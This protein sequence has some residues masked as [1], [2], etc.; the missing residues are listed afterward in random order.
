MRVVW[1]V[2][3]AVE[4]VRALTGVRAF[5]NCRTAAVVHG[6][7]MVAGV[8]FHNYSPEYG[9]IEVSAGA[10]DPR[11]ATRTV[12]QTLFG[13]V[14]EIAQT[15]IARTAEENTRTRRLWKAF[16][17][18]EYILPRLRGR[19]ASEAILLLTDDAW[20]QSKFM[21]PNHGKVKTT[22]AA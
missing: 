21:R 15:C 19:E 3:E 7:K 6:D 10:I 5:D 17:A 11:W 18:Q 14:F 4:F 20:M 1:E 2:P 8:V 13:Y 22:R 16:G 9:L 12:L